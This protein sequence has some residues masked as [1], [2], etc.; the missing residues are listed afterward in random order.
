MYSLSSSGGI[1]LLRG[2]ETTGGGGTAAVIARC[3]ESL[4]IEIV[5][6]KM[7][8]NITNIKAIFATVIFNYITRRKN[9][10]SFF[11]SSA[12][13]KR[14]YVVKLQASATHQDGLRP[15]C[16]TTES[17]IF[18]EANGFAVLRFKQCVINI[19]DSVALLIRKAMRDKHIGQCCIAN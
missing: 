14:H 12:A 11:A 6:A 4:I 9:S 17:P 13:P 3:C 1:T 5:I 19:L 8:T 7:P 15:S 2:S 10:A 18:G 16:Y